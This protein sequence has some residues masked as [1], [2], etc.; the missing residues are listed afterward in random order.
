V[1]VSPFVPI[2]NAIVYLIAGWAG[3][4]LITFLIL[5]VIGTAL[6]V[7]LLAGLGYAL[8]HRAVAVAQTISKYGL[9]FTI[10]LV[11]LVIGRQVWTSQRKR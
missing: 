6:W 11:V 8:G 5:D 4:S 9:W 1:V 2:P 3:M 10:A 7:G